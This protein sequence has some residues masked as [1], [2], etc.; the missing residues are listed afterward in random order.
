MSVTYQNVKITVLAITCDYFHLEGCDE[1][2]WKAAQIIMGQVTSVM[3]LRSRSLCKIGEKLV[4]V[5]SLW[6]PSDRGLVNSVHTHRDWLL[7]WYI[8]WNSNY[9][10]GHPQHLCAAGEVC[11]LWLRLLYMYGSTAIPTKYSVP[12]Q[13]YQHNDILHTGTAILIVDQYYYLACASG[14]YCSLIYLNKYD[15]CHLSVFKYILK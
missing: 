7:W 6:L 15:E 13:V 3:I 8:R 14:V 12:P 9:C 2:R 4:S 1:V 11:H 5:I 10:C